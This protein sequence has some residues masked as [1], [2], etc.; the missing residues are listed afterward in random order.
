M[1][2]G[3]EVSRMLKSRLSRLRGF[4][5]GEALGQTSS[6]LRGGRSR[7]NN[8]VFDDCSHQF[9][10]L[11]CPFSVS[12][13]YRPPRKKKGYVKIPGRNKSVERYVVTQCQAG[14]EVVHVVRH[15]CKRSQP[16]SNSAKQNQQQL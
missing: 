13:S 11:Q 9:L 1:R 12:A 4:Q 8:A 2:L 5:R 3:R 16:S 10:C 6:M 14:G 7:G 15:W